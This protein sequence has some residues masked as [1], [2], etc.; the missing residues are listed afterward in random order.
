MTSLPKESRRSMQTT[1][2]ENNSL[3]AYGRTKQSGKSTGDSL[4]SL[5]NQINDNMQSHNQSART[6]N[7][8]INNDEIMIDNANKRRPSVEIK[9]ID[10]RNL[11][12][13][14][15]DDDNIE[16]ERIQSNKKQKTQILQKELIS[17]KKEE[18]IPVKEILKLEYLGYLTFLCSYKGIRPKV[19][20][21]HKCIRWNSKFPDHNL[22]I[23]YQLWQNNPVGAN[24]ALYFLLLEL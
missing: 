6:V 16:N 17:E 9:P 20:L 19:K 7:R 3:K 24:S 22:A 21:Y 12:R 18:S 23:A 11:K 15:P 13:S 5:H 4:L 10:R 14:K 2:K 1:A 8:L